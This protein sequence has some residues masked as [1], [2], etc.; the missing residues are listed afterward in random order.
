MKSKIFFYPVKDN[1]RKLQLICNKAQE[2]IAQEK[3]LLIAVPNAEAAQFIDTLLWKSPADSFIPHAITQ[4]SSKEWIVITFNN[5]ENLNQAERLLNLC[6]GLHPTFQQFQEVYEL[7]DESSPDKT[8]LS[9]R[10]LDAYKELG[11]NVVVRAE[12]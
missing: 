9:R 8:N 6:H 7:L 1:Q 10:K 11:V 12:G 5:G 3:K 2:S 4:K